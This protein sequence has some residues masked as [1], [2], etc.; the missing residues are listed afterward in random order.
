MVEKSLIRETG[1]VPRMNISNKYTYAPWPRLGKKKKNNQVEKINYP[2]NASQI[3][4]KTSPWALANVVIG[5]E[6]RVCMD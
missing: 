3:L 2:L 5:E 4:S 6:W 1:K